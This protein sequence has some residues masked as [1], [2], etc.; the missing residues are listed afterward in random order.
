MFQQEYLAFSVGAPKTLDSVSLVVF[1][2]AL[3][4]VDGLLYD[5]VPIGAARVCSGPKIQP[6]PGTVSL[7]FCY[8]RLAL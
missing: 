1:A 3:H 8:P 7:V 4:A 5:F 6:T 2:L